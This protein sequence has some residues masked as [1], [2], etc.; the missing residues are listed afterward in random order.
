MP[1]VNYNSQTKL[2]G[3]SYSHGQGGQTITPAR[4]TTIREA[5]DHLKTRPNDRFMRSHLLKSLISLKEE[6]IKLAVELFKQEPSLPLFGF[7]VKT[8]SSSSQYP[9]VMAALQSL[10]M[11]AGLEMF[12]R[13][14]S[15]S[16]RAVLK[17]EAI[18]LTSIWER[19]FSLNRE[20]HLAFQSMPRFSL[21]ITTDLLPVKG[22]TAVN[23]ANF[24]PEV[25]TSISFRTGTGLRTV[26]PMETFARLES[27]KLFSDNDQSISLVQYHG[28]DFALF[29]APSTRRVAVGPHEH[30]LT[31]T[32][33]GS[34]KGLTQ[35]AALVSAV[36][37][38]LER[39]SAAEGVG[40]NWPGGYV[41]DLSLTQKTLAE[42]RRDG[43]AAL[44]PNQFNLE[45]PYENQSLHWVKGEVKNGSGESKIMVPAQ[46]V[47]ENSNLDEVEV[48][49]TSSNGLA[50][51]NT[52]A[53][54]KLHALLEVIE[55]DGD[56]SMYYQPARTFALSAEDQVVGPIIQAYGA[57]GLSVQ[58][59]DLTTEFGVPTYRAFI[60]L[61]E[62]ILSGSGA[63]LDGRIA[64]FRA[65]CELNTKAFIYERHNRSLTPAAEQ[66]AD[67][68]TRQFETLPSFSTMNVEEDLAL[69]E[70][71][72]IANGLSVVYVDLT[73]AD[74]GIPVVRAI[75]PGLDLPPV[76]SRRQVKHLLEMFGSEG[77]VC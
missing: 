23:L 51:G 18:R 68:R 62:Q 43:L 4:E 34:G 17:G 22:K 21:P 30:T 19:Y 54:A 75:V 71:L 3:S 2:T 44:D 7:L 15:P 58:L 77:T 69:A 20:R 37:E 27:V 70:R 64:A 9:A 1:V 49:L 24:K 65:I 28:T 38:A 48:F 50:S 61:H 42:L 36:M 32:G 31:G 66:R 55:R 60:H 72:M 25:S 52:M 53:E 33:H 56:Y 67:V 5:L 57:K 73:R 47:F 11:Q 74:L 35:Q 26:K 63:H 16:V 45:H 14:P 46:I 12:R 41:A 39:Y 8:G 6:G 59:L 76:I 10:G 40:N 29:F 13:H